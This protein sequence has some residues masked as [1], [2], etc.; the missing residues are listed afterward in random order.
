MEVRGPLHPFRMGLE[1]ATAR[2]VDRLQ[3]IEI[4][5]GMIAEQLV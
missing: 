4:R 2:P 1:G 3:R 5:E